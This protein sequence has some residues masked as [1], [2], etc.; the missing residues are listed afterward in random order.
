M[1]TNLSSAQHRVLTALVAAGGA[2]VLHDTS[3]PRVTI[4]KLASLGFVKVTPGGTTST[5]PRSGVGVFTPG[6]ATATITDAGR[7]ALL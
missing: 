5:W 6:P 2:K 1:A 7:E 4:N 3:L